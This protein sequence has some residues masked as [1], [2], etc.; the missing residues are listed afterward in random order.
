MNNKSE[1]L[2][3]ILII[4]SSIFVSFI[5]ICIYIFVTNYDI[6]YDCV[7]VEISDFL[8]VELFNNQ[9]YKYAEDGAVV[10]GTKVKELLVDFIDG[11]I[12]AGKLFIYLP[13]EVTNN[14]SGDIVDENN[15]QISY[16]YE[17]YGWIYGKHKQ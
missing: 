15:Y 8:A 13:I 14:V 2:A 5:I 17:D 7:G 6:T 4:V 3:E 1:I 11:E 16:G 9:F 12:N 10:K